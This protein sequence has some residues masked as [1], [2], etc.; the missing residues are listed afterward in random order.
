MHAKSWSSSI[1]A[2]IHA[3][4]ISRHHDIDANLAQQLECAGP[5]YVYTNEKAMLDLIRMT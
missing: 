5:C 3:W 2:Y 1:V 4:L